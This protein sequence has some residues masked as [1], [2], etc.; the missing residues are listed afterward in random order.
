[1]KQARCKLCR[2][3]ILKSVPSNCVCGEIGFDTEGRILFRDINNI[4]AINDDGS[5][6]SLNVIKNGIQKEITYEE[7]LAELN[8]LLKNIEQL[9]PQAMSTAITHYDFYSVCLLIVACLRKLKP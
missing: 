4:I 1:M 5:E 9:P 3:T 2:D 6:S 8:I 7:I